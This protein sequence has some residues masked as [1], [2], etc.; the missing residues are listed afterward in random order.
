MGKGILKR[1]TFLDLEVLTKGILKTAERDQNQEKQE[2]SFLKIK[3]YQKLTSIS[4][5]QMKVIWISINN[6]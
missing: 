2:N 1:E 5:R 4:K 6:Q 3:M